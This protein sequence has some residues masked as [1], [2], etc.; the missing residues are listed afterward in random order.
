VDTH[1][2]ESVARS[3]R[4]A[5][6]AALPLVEVNRR[7]TL[8]HGTAGSIREIWQYRELLGRLV[9]REVKVR[10]K[11][12]SLGIL[13]SLFRPLVQ[14]LIY[15]F[16][17]GQVLGA[18]RSVPD[19]AIFVFIGLTMWAL[20]SEIL[21]SATVSIIGNSGLVK[22]VYLPREIFPLASVGSAFVNFCIQLV[23]LLL[24]IALLSYFQFGWTLLYAP[25]AVATILVYGTALG[26]AL[27][28]LNVYFRDVQHFTE[29]FIL[30]F[31]W[32]SP[33]VYSFT[34]VHNELQGNWLEQL[35]LA[36]PITIA[37]IAAQKALWAAGSTEVNGMVQAWPDFLSLRL[38]IAFLV[39]LV[40]L[41]LAHRLFARIQGNFAQ[42][43]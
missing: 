13:W 26:F 25:A 22:K 28:A 39:G 43:L 4:A 30:I 5:K 29:I 19:F 27:S 14:L 18:A 34:F 41:W 31:F 16:A 12:S 23:V 11:D 7:T 2:R 35:Y 32:V 15:Y 40:L 37:V 21:A 3:E 8:L 20:F 42:E 38:L 10:Y 17:I 9:K 24:G 1:E 36:N 33:I 6:I